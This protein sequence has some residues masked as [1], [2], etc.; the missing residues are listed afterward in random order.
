MYDQYQNIKRHFIWGFEKLASLGITL[1]GSPLMFTLAFFLVIFWLGNREFY[2]EGIH[3]SIEDIILGITFLSMF[4]IQKS[5][6]KFA[7]ALNLKLNE[8]IVSH[9][10]A[11]NEVINIEQKTEHEIAQ[12]TKEYNELVDEIKKEA[13][14]NEAK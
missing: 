11:S 5:A 1:L 14:N 13:D 12:L 4:I 3:K 6:N 10:A 7:A 9:E 8:L 2:N